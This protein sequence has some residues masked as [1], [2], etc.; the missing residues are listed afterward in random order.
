[1]YRIALFAIFAT[2]PLMLGGPPAAAQEYPWCAV[3]GWTTSNCGFV[4]FRQCQATISG[5]GGIC[6]RNPR[7]NPYQQRWRG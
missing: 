4:S 1:M 2:T 6:E 7:Y 3:Y 5:I